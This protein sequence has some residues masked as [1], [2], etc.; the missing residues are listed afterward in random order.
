MSAQVNIQHGEP[1]R[2]LRRLISALG[3]A[4]RQEMHGAMGYEVQVLTT[5][6]L[7]RIAS[8]RHKTAN[9]LGA[10]PSGHLARAA[11][12]VAQPGALSST[13]EEAVITI[14]HPGM[15]RAFRDVQIRPKEAKSLAI[16]I[17]ALAY[18]RR[19][20]ELWKS[21]NLFIPEGSRYIAMREADRTV[22]L[23]VLVRSVTQKQDRTLL[24]S[25]DDMRGAAA[26][27]CKNYIRNAIRS[28]GL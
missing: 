9:R 25:N 7:R 21:H 23:Y 17:H 6:Y 15:S 4:G 18:N 24:P 10:S 8:S 13:S 20:A 27:G 16:P 5:D 12:K 11:E 2:A 14:K 1:S 22:L 26:L 3:P 19:A 28:G